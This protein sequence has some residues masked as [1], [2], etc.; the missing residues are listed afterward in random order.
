MNLETKLNKSLDNVLR[1]TGYVFEIVNHNRRNSNLL[2]GP[3]GQLLTLQ[4]SEHLAQCL[5]N[6]DDILDETVG[7]LNDARW[8]I[9]QIVE[10]KH[11]QEELKLKEE[12]ERQRRQEEE[13][14][15][16]EEKRVAE[17]RRRA[18]EQKEREAQAARE[19]S[20][21]NEAEEKRRQA[22]QVAA[23]TE[24]VENQNPNAQMQA[25]AMLQL[26]QPLQG[27]VQVQQQPQRQNE[28]AISTMS[29]TFDFNMDDIPGM[30]ASP[31][32]RGP[33]DPSGSAG[34]ID[35]GTKVD[36]PNPSDILQSISYDGSENK[37]PQAKTEGAGADLDFEMN[38]LL[39]SDTLLLDGLNVGLLEPGEGDGTL[40]EGEEFDVDSFLNQFGGGD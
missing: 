11:K 29:P 9:E 2:A 4:V 32:I 40:G 8:C 38:N 31:S 34:P 27:S 23:S 21:R 5:Q 15:A 13:K 39:G 17:E 16:E 1:T 20:A 28:P 24:A 7:K 35:Q 19:D 14:R 22:A 37:I 10:N 25:Q 18:E 30:A 26:P 12:V 33:G 3:N 6:F 36:I